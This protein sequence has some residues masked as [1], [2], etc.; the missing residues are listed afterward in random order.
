MSTIEPDSGRDTVADWPADDWDDPHGRN[1]TRPASRD[2]REVEVVPSRWAD[3]A[4]EVLTGPAPRRRGWILAAVAGAAIAAT[5]WWLLGRTPE[6]PTVTIAPA[7][8]TAHE[9]PTPS[10]QPDITA[11]VPVPTTNTPVPTGQPATGP[12][13]DVAAGFAADY[14]NP[15]AGKDDWLDRISRWT[16]PQLTDGYRL[17]DPNRLP[18]AQLQR[19]SPPLNNDSGTVIYDAFYDTLTLEIRV[20]FLDDRWQVIAALDTRPFDDDVSPP[21]STPPQT[22]PYLPPDIGAPQPQP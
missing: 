21:G 18:A 22:T 20:A 11:D 15:G 9:T 7:T 19:L 17:T 16:S 2:P 10:A 12:A 1:D 14:A 8:P 4:D 5:V 3:R 6:G 13:N